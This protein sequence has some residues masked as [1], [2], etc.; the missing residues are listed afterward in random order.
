MSLGERERSAVILSF[1]R[2][3]DARCPVQPSLDLVVL[4]ADEV[5]EPEGWDEGDG[6]ADADG[7]GQHPSSSGVR[8]DDE[9]VV[10][11]RGGECLHADLAGESVEL[12]LYFVDDSEAGQGSFTERN[13]RRAEGVLRS[14]PAVYPAV[15]LEREE[16]RKAR[17]AVDAGGLGQV[18]GGEL[19]AG[20]G[21]EV[22][23]EADQSRC[24][25]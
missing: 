3:E 6:L 5:G 25:G 17:R 1:A 15:V 20:R 7:V 14:I 19:V 13:Q 9:I 22:F 21:S 16:E 24:G 18:A 8:D 12:R 10:G 4:G 2:G 11:E 23:E